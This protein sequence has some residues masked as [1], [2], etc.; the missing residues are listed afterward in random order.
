[1]RRWLSL[2]AAVLLLDISL[3][4][5]NVWPTPAIRWHGHLSIELAVVIL[6]MALAARWLP[7]PSRPIVRVLAVIWAALTIGHYAEVTAPALYG[8]DIN[9]YW[10][11]RFIPDV[12]AMVTRVARWWQIVLSATAAAVVL[13]ALYV[14]ARWALER[15]GAAMSA[16]RERQALAIAALG[17]VV[18]FVGARGAA[19]A[20]ASVVFAPPVTA[21]YAAQARFVAQALM[22]STA[23]PPSPAMD[24][25]LSRVKDADVFLVFIEAYGAVSFERPVI[26]DRLAGSRHQLEKSIQ[27]SGRR[28]VSAYV[29]SPTFGGSSWLAHISLMSG[30]EV[31]DPNTNARLMTE[32]RDT[33]PRAFAR[34]GF[35]TVAL[36]PGL[37]QAWPEGVFYGFD[38]I[39]GADRLAYHG[40]EFGWFA[41][42][43]QFALFRLDELEVWRSLRSP[44]FVFFP[45]ISTHFPFLPTPPYQT[46]WSRM[47]ELRPYD[48]PAIVR[49]Y[50]RQPDWMNFA[51]GYVDAISYDFATLGGYLERHAGED[52]VMIVLGDHQPAAVVSGEGAA[53]DVPVHV[54]ASRDA[55]LDRF[56][57][58]GFRDGLTPERPAFGPMHALL[59][60]VLDAF[61]DRPR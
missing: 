15:I 58:H 25:D 14:T 48:G 5:E 26:A 40:P 28:V 4:F 16:P 42:P 21:T 6:A 8:R 2:A 38:E 41:I 31:H 44:L 7:P 55:V 51:P 37:R 35:R 23:L 22:R 12:V 43:D 39:Y 57:T 27:H 36:M 52:V 61:G 50:G 59:P 33:L 17:A 60:I 11:L 29:T 47:P 32:Q 30:I 3:T 20:S 18:L 56:R 45:T 13:G 9:L 10:D 24:S 19:G 1:M 49:A 46:N 34:R 53:W 54:I